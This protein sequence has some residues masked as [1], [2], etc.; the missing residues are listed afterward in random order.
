MK[1]LT[2]IAEMGSGG[3]EAVVA[4]LT[5]DALER[6]DTV[7][8]A[9]SGGWRGDE[10][11]RHGTR[12]V[13]LTLRGRDPRDIVASI[14]TLRTELRERRPDLVHVH[15]VKAAVVAQAAFLGLRR[16]PVLVTLHGIPARAYPVAA[17]V[18]ARSADRLIVVS[19]DVQERIV[20]AGFPQHS[21]GVIENAVAPLPRHDRATARRRLSVAPDAQVAVCVARLM[22]PKRHDLLI[23][24]WR[25][26][27]P[28]AVLLLAGDGDRRADIAG[29]V[30]SA[31]LA[32]RVHLLGERRDVDWL[33]AAADLCVLPTDSEGLPISLLE[34][35]G[36]GVAVVAS[37]VGGLRSALKNGACL[38]PPGSAQ[39]LA[40]GINRVLADAEYRTSLAARGITLVDTRFGLARMLEAYLSSYRELLA[41]R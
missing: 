22:P 34:A 8:L 6:G 39:A 10:L 27:P 23:E 33:L 31:G 14:R 26:T 35:M 25:Q 15:N 5:H 16:P 36:A 18:L 41:S 7:A 20:R 1:L 12:L 4:V 37:A 40:D 19:A 11:A 29:A 38:V 9:S 3:A 13:P 24:A 2:V 21:V 17:R 32:D 28:G 30:Q